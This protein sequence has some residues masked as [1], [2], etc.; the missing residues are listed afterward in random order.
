MLYYP[1]CL[2]LQIACVFD[3]IGAL[4]LGR[5]T[6]DVIKSGIAKTDT[7]SREPEM[8]AYGMM[9]VM[10]VSAVWQGIGCYYGWNV[11]GGHSISACG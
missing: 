10:F 3:F 4:A 5:V 9:I 1:I 2:L 6:Q 11:S 7:F 8:Y